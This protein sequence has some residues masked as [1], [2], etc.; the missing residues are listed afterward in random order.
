[1]NKPTKRSTAFGKRLERARTEKGIS[2]RDLE[3][4]LRC[5]QSSVSRWE[6]GQKYPKPE[7][8]IKLSIALGVNA[9]WLLFGE[10]NKTK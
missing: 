9:G 6:S 2:Q 7:M 4:H 1:M 8:I 10:E 3:Y 5:A